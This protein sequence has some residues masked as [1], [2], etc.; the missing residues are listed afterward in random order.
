[1]RASSRVNNNSNSATRWM[2]TTPQQ[3]SGVIGSHRRRVGGATAPAA[4]RGP[5]VN[6]LNIFG[7][8]TKEKEKQELKELEGVSYDLLDLK[9]GAEGSVQAAADVFERVDDVVMGGVSSSAI[10]PDLA[11][12]DCLVWAGKCRVQGGGFTG[13]AP[14]GGELLLPFSKM[15]TPVSSHLL[16][17]LSLTLWSS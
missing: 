17:V 4:A 15:C 9:N 12:R 14:L 7:G 3:R 8:S 16:V 10:G 13:K 2:T 5:T 1:M 6:F 11:G